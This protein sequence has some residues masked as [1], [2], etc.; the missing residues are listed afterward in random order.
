MT[1]I[2]PTK[3]RNNDEKPLQ[4]R[5]KKLN[6]SNKQSSMI[7]AGLTTSSTGA[8]KHEVDCFQEAKGIGA[9]LAPGGDKQRE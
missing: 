7:G 5:S 6:P 1:A 4:P 8:S 3:A 2:S 9:H